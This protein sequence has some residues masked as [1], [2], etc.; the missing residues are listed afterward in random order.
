M[1]VAF[2]VIEAISPVKRRSHFPGSGDRVD[3]KFM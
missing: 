1:T 2:L 3:V